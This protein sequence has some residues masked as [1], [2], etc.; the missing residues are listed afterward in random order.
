MELLMRLGVAM[1]IVLA[2]LS[3]YG[4]WSRARLY[5]LRRRVSGNR[6]YAGLEELRAGVPAILYF[7]TPQCIPCRTIQGPAIEELREQYRDRLHII[8][9]D[10]SDRTDLANYWGVL[11]IPTTFIIDGA[12]QPRH[13]NNGVTTAPK[14]R[15]QL[16]EFAGLSDPV[17]HTPHASQ[18]IGQ[19]VWHTRRS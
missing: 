18:P 17:D 12:G 3:L 14:L 11:S 7:T 10:A 8:K 2:G 6:R 13:V 5:L 16:R 19:E 9:I 15:Q 1:L 4:L